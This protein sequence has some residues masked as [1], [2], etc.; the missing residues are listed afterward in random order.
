[1]F[2]VD[3]DSH[4]EVLPERSGT[5][6][7]ALIQRLTRLLERMTAAHNCGEYYCDLCDRAASATRAARRFL[8]T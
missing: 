6:E 4:G 5:T 8:E 3:C 1:M 7:R 2:G